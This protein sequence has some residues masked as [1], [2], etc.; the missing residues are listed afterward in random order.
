MGKGCFVNLLKAGPLHRR[1]LKKHFEKSGGKAVLGVHVF[2]RPVWPEFMPENE[3]GREVYH[4][5]VA[6]LFSIAEKNGAPII[7][8]EDGGDVGRLKARISSAH[9]GLRA[10]Y[11][12]SHLKVPAPD[13]GKLAEHGRNDYEAFAEMLSNLGV[14]KMALFGRRHVHA[15]KADFFGCIPE[16][17]HGLDKTGVFENPVR[18]M[19]GLAHPDGAKHLEIN[20]QRKR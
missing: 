1:R 10:Y 3:G 6:K 12:E 11:V 18:L 7:F 16:V 8:I 13:M 9:P 19:Y 14:R 5:K 17:R 15:G 2:Y 20:R 4:R